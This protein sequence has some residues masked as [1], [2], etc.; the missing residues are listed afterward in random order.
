MCR[1]SARCASH[2]A[3][4]LGLGRGPPIGCGLLGP[5]KGL[6]SGQILDSSQTKCGQKSPRGH[7]YVRPAQ[8][9]GPAANGDEI[10]FQELSEHFLATNAPDGLDLCPGDGLPVGHDRERLQGGRRQPARGGLVEQPTDPRPERPPAEQL[11]APGDLLHA[12]SG[13]SRVLKLPQFPDERPSP[14][15]VR[16][17]CQFRQTADRQRLAGQ[18]ER[19]L[20]PREFLRPHVVTGQ[21]GRFGRDGRSLE[22]PVS[23]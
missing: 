12:K 10:A 23:P 11:V 18:K 9:F 1:P 4:A 6:D 3:V 16:Q 22:K 13:A 5:K 14:R 15:S 7:V 21:S 2:P 20:Q 8:I 19:R 17:P